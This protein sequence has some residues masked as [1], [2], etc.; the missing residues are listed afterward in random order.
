M[1]IEWTFDDISYYF[2]SLKARNATEKNLL[3]R[4]QH[5]EDHGCAQCHPL[6]L[7]QINPEKMFKINGKKLPGHGTMF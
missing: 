4:R 5:L 3:Q 6:V 2:L 7:P 1:Y